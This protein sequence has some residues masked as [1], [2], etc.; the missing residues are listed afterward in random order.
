MQ[1]ELVYKQDVIDAICCDIII[2]GKK[3]AETVV[4]TL[5]KIIDRVKALP[6]AEPEITMEEVRE[7]CHERGLTIISDETY[8]FTRAEL[9]VHDRHVRQEFA[10]ECCK[11]LNK[12]KGKEKQ[13]D[14][15]EH[16]AGITL[17]SLD[18]YRKHWK[19]IKQINAWWWLRS[20]GRTKSRAA[21]VRPD[22]YL[23]EYGGLVSAIDLT[24]RPALVLYGSHEIG[25]SISF[26]GK[27]WTT[28]SDGL[29]LADEPLC[30][31]PFRRDW[32]ASDASSY[33]KSD[34]RE[35]LGTWLI[36]AMER[37]GK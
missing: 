10:A 23:S 18:E 28:I 12:Q 29:A 4:T 32:K 20:P 6:L 36:E 15:R 11:A 25:Q 31:M 26:G 17:L 2:T 37:E 7:F 9:E 34:I 13:P 8:T 3:N 24:V 16:I 27:T 5:G 14:I 30:D 1:K 21:Y 33:D 35:Y 19:N 22:G